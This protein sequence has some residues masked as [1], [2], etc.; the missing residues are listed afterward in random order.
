[1]RTGGGGGWGD[2]LARAAALVAA[3]AAEGLISRQAARELYGV[4]LRANLSL[5]ESATRRLRDR[6]RSRR[7]GRPAKRASQQKR[8]SLA[9]GT[10]RR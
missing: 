6:L 4:V 2:P 8:P 10:K 5:D 1:V 3:D 7:K 9:N